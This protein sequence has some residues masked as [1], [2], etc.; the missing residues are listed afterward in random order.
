MTIDIF[1]ILIIKIVL[2]RSLFDPPPEDLDYQRL[3][4][5]QPGGF[6]WGRQANENQNNENL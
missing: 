6:Q 2:R 5:E 4:E 1:Q 3:P